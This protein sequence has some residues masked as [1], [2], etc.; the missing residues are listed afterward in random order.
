MRFHPLYVF[1]ALLGGPELAFEPGQKF[2][3]SNIGYWLL[4]K[5][6]E[7]ATGQSYADYVRAN[8]LRPLGISAYEM[9]FVIPDPDRHANRA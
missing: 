2:A 6:A 4:G 9:D 5:I 3:Y 7:Q 1:F 8:I